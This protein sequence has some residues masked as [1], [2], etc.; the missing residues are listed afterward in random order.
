MKVQRVLVAGGGSAGLLAALSI[1]THLPQVEVTLVRS[2]ELGVIGVGEGSTVGLPSFLHGYLRIPPGEFLTQ[3]RPTWKLGLRFTHWGPRPHFHYS[4]APSMYVRWNNLPKVAAFYCTE[5]MDNANFATA[6]MEHD[7]VFLRG[8]NGSPQMTRDFGYHVENAGFVETLEKYASARG[9]ALIDDR[10]TSVH[11]DEGG[12]ISGIDCAGG[13]SRRADLYVDC[14][15]F[16]SLLLGKTLQEKFRSFSSTLFCDRA[17][18]GGWDRSVEPVKPYT[19]VEPMD[20]GWSWQIEHEH[21]INRGYVYSSHFSSDEKA[22]REFREQN[23]KVETT[24]IVRFISGRYENAWRQNVVAL[25]NAC[26]FVEP[27]EATSLGAIC[28]EAATLVEALQDSDG[29][30]TASQIRQF[31]YRIGASWD[32]IRRFLAIHYRFNT[33][34]QT[35]F[36]KACRAEVDLAGAEA[37]VDFY[38]ENGPSDFA[39]QALLSPFDQFTMDGWLTLLVGQQVTTQR[40]YEPTPSERTTWEQIRVHVRAR[41]RD[42]FTIPQALAVVRSPRWKWNPE[43]FPK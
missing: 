17:V 9:V 8:E 18:V 39:R 10:I 42:A 30:P 36:W 4:F 27:L 5:E 14:S 31:N 24:R 7:R 12:A 32:N 13:T 41:T 22:E 37:I 11:R 43:F 1:K 28:S 3:A 29:A 35:S 20:A 40:K 21:R 38:A 2:R 33:R 6:L 15:G 34:Q 16:E 26:G 19:S 23:P 25:G